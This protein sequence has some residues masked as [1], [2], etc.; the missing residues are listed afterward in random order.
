MRQILTYP[1]PVLR[2]KAESVTEI[3]EEIN[4][5]I[6]EMADL[7]Y[8]DDGVGLAA[9][10][11]GVAKQI[12]VID[13]GEGF[14]SLINPVVIDI[15]D[16]EESLEE[17]CLSLPGI[18]ITIS[19]PVNIKVSALNQ[20]SSEIEI[21]AEGLIARILQH[22]IDHINGIMIIDHASSIQRGLLRSRLKKMEK[23]V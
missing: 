8:Q 14:K 12:I 20:N 13:A 17:G 1:D 3:N 6:D 23:N 18:R 19:R 4:E 9:N 21:E 10:Q 5:L 16:K 11:A 7:M 2:E 15:S 22:E